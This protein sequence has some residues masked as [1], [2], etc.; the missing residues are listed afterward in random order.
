MRAARSWLWV[1]I[2]AASLDARTSRISPSKTMTGG[3]RIEVAGRLV[4][5]QQARRVGDGAGDRHALLLAAGE[6][7]RPV[8]R[9]DP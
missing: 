1:A 5:E 7:R 9:R 3:V 2:S 6:L 4:G 8:R